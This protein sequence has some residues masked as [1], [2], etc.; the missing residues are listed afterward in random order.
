VNQKFLG[1]RCSLCGEEYQP[2]EAVY[3]CTKDGGNLD[4]IY[5]FDVLKKN[6][7]AES[8]LKTRQESLWR[9][10]HLLPV[11]REPEFATPIR[12]VGWTPIYSPNKL[13]SDLGLPEL[14]IKDE[15]RNP[16]ASFKDRASAVVVARAKE[17]G[18]EVVVTILKNCKT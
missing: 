16:T 12:S 15:S 8:L 2:D 10:L 11:K 14:W 18:A 7:T 1:Y 5:D 6:L 9:Y 4:I 3:V 17:I 13:K